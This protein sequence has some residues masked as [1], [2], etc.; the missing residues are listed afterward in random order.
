MTITHLL[1]VGF[2]ILVEHI[3]FGPVAVDCPGGPIRIVPR[4]YQPPGHVTLIEESHPPGLGEVA[5]VVQVQ[6]G[7][8]ESEVACVG[9]ADEFPP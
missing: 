8:Q 4:G 7:I 2:A 5:L 6:I 1:H 3:L 9:I